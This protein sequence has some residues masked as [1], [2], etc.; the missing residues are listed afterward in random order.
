M[1]YR[2]VMSPTVQ[3]A[4]EICL[5]YVKGDIILALDRTAFMPHMPQLMREALCLCPEVKTQLGSQQRAVATRFSADFNVGV[6][7]AEAAVATDAVNT[8]YH[9]IH[10]R[11]EVNSSETVFLFGLGGLGFNALQIVLAIGARIVVCDIRQERLDEAK[12]LGVP[13][14]DIVPVGQSP[15]EFVQERGLLIDTVLDFVGTHQTFEDA[16]HIGS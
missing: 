8:A 9:A 7:P 11:G 13:E 2:A 4:R 3:N 16:Q 12:S 10:R 15:Q 5:K 1:L 6:T 14:Q